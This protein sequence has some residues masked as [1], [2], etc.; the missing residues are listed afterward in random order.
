VIRLHPANKPAPPLA[1]SFTFGRGWHPR[2]EDGWRWAYDDAALSYFNPYSRPFAIDIQFEA[3]GPTPRELS[4]E[5]DGA[6]VST[7]KVGESPSKQILSHVK[8]S[9]GI[10]RFKL[11]CG[12]RAVRRNGARNQLRS[13]GLHEVSVRPSCDTVD[14]LRTA[15]T[16]PGRPAS[17]HVDGVSGARVTKAFKD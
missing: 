8:L 15:T 12:T 17:P 6:I 3:M 9:P 10:N 16:S 1:E 5:H 13:F 4:L 11:R 7:L 14:Q 2:P